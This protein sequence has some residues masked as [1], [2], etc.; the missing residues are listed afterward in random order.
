MSEATLKDKVMQQAIQLSVMG[1]QINFLLRE[2]YKS[3]QEHEVFVKNTNL[4]ATVKAAVETEAKNAKTK[5][6]VNP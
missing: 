3:N 1:K 2:L 4:A 5:E 6:P